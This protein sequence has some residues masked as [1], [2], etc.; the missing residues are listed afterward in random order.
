MVVLVRNTIMKRPLMTRGRPARA[1]SACGAIAT[2]GTIL[3]RSR[4]R[5]LHK[6]N[7]LARLQRL[8]EQRAGRIQG[9]F[10]RWFRSR[11]GSVAWLACFALAFQLFAAFGHIH[12][13]TSAGSASV[14]ALSDT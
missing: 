9:R 6:M 8:R 2:S 12:L 7:R 4:P 3:R 11:R 14:L 13:G 5:G 10:M 1:N